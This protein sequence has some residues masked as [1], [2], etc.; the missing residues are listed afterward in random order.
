[1][2]TDTINITL[3][4]FNSVTGS[5]FRVSKQQAAR[6]TLTDLS[7]EDRNS[8]VG[9]SAEDVANALH[10]RNKN[11]KA[12]NWVEEAVN[13]LNEGWNSSMELTREGALQEFI[14]EGGLDKLKNRPPEIPLS[15]YLDAELTPD[16]FT[17]KV[18]E[19]IGVKRRFRMSQDQYA[20]FKAGELTREQAL[21]ETVEAKRAEAEAAANQ[22]E[23][24][25]E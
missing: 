23:N 14:S 18:E 5:R 9:L 16:N 13:L 11:G 25:N 24:S 22:E 7:D 3:E 6:I 4:N 17:Q 1:M 20:R 15:V 8:L 19:A 2:N 10:A 12:L 21:A